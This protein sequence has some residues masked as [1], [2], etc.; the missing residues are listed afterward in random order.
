MQVLIQNNSRPWWRYGM[1]WMVI[2][3]PLVVVIAAIATAYIAFSGSD[4]VMNTAEPVVPS[5]ERNWVPAQQ[6]R[7]HAATPTHVTIAR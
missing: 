3:G 5:L 6:A 2:S 1:V 4:A 7:N